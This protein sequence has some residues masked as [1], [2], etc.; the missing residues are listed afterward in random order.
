MIL[1]GCHLWLNSS[2]EKQSYFKR[3]AIK[4]QEIENIL[5][6]HVDCH[7]VKQIDVLLINQWQ[8]QAFSSSATFPAK[9]DEKR[10]GRKLCMHVGLL[11][12]TRWKNVHLLY[13]ANILSI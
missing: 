4:N 1:H 6:K 12:K 7:L 13:C 8:I 11:V 10:L 9:M 2:W 3:E 5:C